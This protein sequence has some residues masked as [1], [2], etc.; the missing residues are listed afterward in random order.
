MNGRVGTAHQKLE[1]ADKE[2]GGHCP[3]YYY[4]VGWVDKPNHWE[5]GR[6]STAEVAS[7]SQYH[8][9]H[10]GKDYPTHNQLGAF[11]L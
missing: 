5:D 10:K 8:S 1:P 7:S 3:P 4:F 2:N 6:R 9:D 11:I